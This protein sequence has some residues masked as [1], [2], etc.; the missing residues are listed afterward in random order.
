[1]AAKTTSAAAKRFGQYVLYGEI[2]AGG[3]ATIHFG[4]LISPDGSARVVAIKRLHPQFAKDAEFRTMFL[5]EARVAVH[6]AHPNVVP[7]L[8]VVGMENELFLV[9]EYVAGESLSRLI[10]QTR[11]KKKVIPPRIVASVLANALR[12]LHAAHGACDAQGN[13][14]HIVHRDMSPQNVLVGVDGTSRVLDFGVAKAV[15]RH[16]QT[17]EGQL[18]GKIAY[19]APEQLNGSV[20][21]RTDVYAAGV[22]LWEALTGKRLFNADNEAAIL[23]KILSGNVEPPSQHIP[24]SDAATAD[25]LRQLDAIVLKALEREER[26]R[27]ASALEMAE[28]LEQL[29]IAP[30]N[31]IAKFVEKTASDALRRRNNV[32]AAIEK[33]A[34]PR[35]S[36]PPSAS[37]SGPQDAL[38][39]EPRTELNSVTANGPSTPHR[40]SQS[41]TPPAIEPPHGSRG[42]ISSSLPTAKRKSSGAFVLGGVLAVALIFAGIGLVVAARSK[43]AARENVIAPAQ[44]VVPENPPAAVAPPPLVPSAAPSAVPSAGA[45]PA[46]ADTDTVEFTTANGNPS[47]PRRAAPPR[48]PKCEPSFIDDQGHKQYRPECM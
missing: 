48:K 23:G 29:P 21:P 34:P 46:P 47:Q 5:D 31:E 17:R 39:S 37:A 2:A 27:F 8:D 33:N 11:D 13:P 20:S 19:M 22:T 26:D 44:A 41:G 30:P 7:T 38:T 24:A 40:P 12:G 25:L 42:S 10:R 45:A 4:R 16:Q 32:L 28:A 14:L 18:K 15:G 3:M 43:D 6:V 9:M 1:V 36:I 35:P